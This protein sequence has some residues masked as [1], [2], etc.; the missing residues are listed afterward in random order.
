MQFS[1][2][3]HIYLT[4]SKLIRTNQLIWVKYLRLLYLFLGQLVELI[5]VY[6]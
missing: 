1:T 6:N 3:I 5:L 2:H 4:D